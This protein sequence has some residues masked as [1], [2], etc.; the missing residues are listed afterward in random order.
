MSIVQIEKM[1]NRNVLHLARRKDEDRMKKGLSGNRQPL[2]NFHKLQKGN[3][4][5]YVKS[6]NRRLSY[7]KK[8]KRRS[9][10]PLQSSYIK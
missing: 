4:L 3:L 10:N 9:A 8:E 5:L 6:I 7:A 2:K 1:Q